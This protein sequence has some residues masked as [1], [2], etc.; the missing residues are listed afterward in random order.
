MNISLHRSR[1]QHWGLGIGLLL[2]TPIFSLSIPLASILLAGVGSGSLH[3]WLWLAS[4]FIGSIIGVYL[5]QGFGL[6]KAV[7]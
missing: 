6:D 2:I 5:R 4:G 1:P 7:K 3:G